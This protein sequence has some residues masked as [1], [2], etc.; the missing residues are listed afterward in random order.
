MLR[1]TFRTAFRVI[2]R[3]PGFAFINL[4]GLS[5]GVAIALLLLLFARQ[6]NSF[7]TFHDKSDR[8]YRAWVLED[9]GE[10]Q[11]FFN[12][13]TPLPLAGVLA[14]AIP[15]IET[16]A[17]YD[18]FTDTVRRGSVEFNETLFVVDHS[19]FDVFDFPMVEGD[20]TAP[21]N[22][23]ESVILTES[24]AN[25]YFGAERAIGQELILQ[26]G[27]DPLTLTVS[28]VL[29]D[30]PINSSLQFEMLLP[31]EVSSWMYPERMFTAW[32]NVVSETW[33]VLREGA[34]I[35]AV[36]ARI[37]EIMAT[38]LGDRVEPGQYNVG[39]QPMESIHL[40]PSFPIGYAPV[41]NPVYVRL[42]MGIA[43]LVLLIACINFVT[44]SLSQAPS[45]SR[46][47]GV[48]K[49]IGAARSQ[50]VSQFM[51]EA[52]LFSGMAMIL[53]LGLA[54]VLLPGFNH[55]S[56]NQLSFHLEGTTWLMLGSVFLGL[57]VFI[58][59]YPSLVMSSY[60]PTE[61]FRGGATEGRKSGWLRKS[62]VTVQF[63]ISMA[64][65]SAMLVMGSQLR[66]I[67]SADLGF[68]P[69]RVLYVPVELPTDEAYDLAERVRFATASRSDIESVS[70]SRMLFDE[71]GWGRIG[72]NATDGSYRRFFA[73][74]VDPEFVQTMGLRMKSGR[75]FDRDNPS[76]M[77][78]A[79]IVNEAFVQAFG[80]D[81][82]L[83]ET[84]PG[85]FNEHEII[86]V[87]E[88]FHFTSLH[89]DVE[90]A[91]L[92]VSQDLIFSGAND[93]DYQG[94]FIGRIA[95]RLSGTDS[96]STL[97]W[98]ESIWPD[99]ANGLPFSYRF[100]DQDIQSQYDQELRLASITRL[101]AL[102]AMLI[103]GLGLFGLAAIS[104]ARRTKE[105]GIRKTLGASTG[106][107]V[108]LFGR[109]FMPMV[110]LALV[111]AGPLAWTGLDRWLETFAY[112]TELGPWPFFAAGLGALALMW[113][114]VSAQ[115]IKAA[116]TNPVSALKDD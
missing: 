65:L 73:N 63:S 115:S 83:S 11:Q 42:L 16:T 2:S 100:V 37:P 107:I 108:G 90:P 24:A 13:I 88:D 58:G 111:V 49:A 52:I 7:D 64:M 84:I 36:E 43:L 34:D 41:A 18:R 56:F 79:L 86:G 102:L 4:A 104:V 61:A 25:R 19:F 85:N 10:D 32:F 40:D 6:E 30:V 80:W 50:L 60:R 51:G 20:L 47:I 77:E 69:D 93:F 105:I 57:T 17:R 91:V 59:T 68:S 55:L 92:S 103:A 12:T 48:R 9:Y 39:L 116:W 81:D 44:L 75:A 28:A 46:E 72:F 99:V 29:E 53:G 112:R 98:L 38:A 106:H 23:P 67:E 14:D 82:P 78:R 89:S 66:F 21:F 1:N 5:G 35:E 76:D 87:V 97:A 113:V 54:R 15:E 74:I 94:A 45:R 33:V 8:T 3:R 95:L 110:L 26:R 101:G 71:N 31:F 22:G 27:E 96:N 62:L 70:A 109:E 114:A